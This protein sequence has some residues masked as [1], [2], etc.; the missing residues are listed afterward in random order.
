MKTSTQLTNFP[1]LRRNP[2]LAE[3]TAMLE[4]FPEAALFVDAKSK[5]ILG[6]NSKTSELTLYTHQEL[7]GLDSARLFENFDDDTFWGTTTNESHPEILTLARQNKTGVQVLVTRYDLSPQGKWNL[8]VL[9]PISVL[10]QRLAERQ[11]RSELLESMNTI[12]QALHETELKPGLELLLNAAQ[13]MTGA[14]T[15]GI[16]LQNLA[17][18]NQ[19]FEVVRFSHYGPTG[20]LPEELPA[21]E[22]AQLRT[23]NFWTTS[24]RVPTSLHRTARSAGLTYVASVPLGQP[25]AMIGLVVIAGNQTPPPDQ[26]LEQLQILAEAISALVEHHTRRSNIARDLKDM[27]WQ[28]NIHRAIENVVFDGVIVLDPDLTI[29][30]LNYACESILGYSN[31]E[32]QKHSVEDILIGTETLMPALK[33][34]QQGDQTLKQAN[35]RLYHRSGQAFLAQVSTVPTIVDEKL[36]GIIILIQDLSEQEQIQS[37][38]QELER[39]A[40][41]GEVTAIFAHEVRNPINNISTGLQL[42]AYN[43]P[44]DDPKQEVI[45][46]LNQ[47]C[48][49]LSELMKSVLAFSR[50]AEYEMVAIDLC[51]LINR[52]VDRARPRMSNA[53]VEPHLQFDDSL[54]PIEGNQRA[55]EQVF[56]NLIS[57]AIQA[58]RKTGGTLAIK[59][60]KIQSSGDSHY[61]QVDVADSGPGIPKENIDRIFQPFFTTKSDGTGLGLAITKRIVTAHKGNIQVTSF[62]GG[63]VF[64]VQLPVLEAL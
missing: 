55:L 62:P 21:L 5:R 47:D 7:S 8:I 38:T 54:P 31:Q 20:N 49:R 63:T 60:Q 15:L 3:I 29:S 36:L 34:A 50:P 59:M 6:T 12:S 40:L 35:M 45:G 39:Q 58:M 48:D 26:V 18:N 32:A 25:N 19:D 9:E 17:K 44:E 14:S 23:A 13:T 53:K 1:R 43:L 56:T 52:L 27:T 10:E 16:Y 30:R 11:R 41:L 37:Q 22:L 57:N 46:R 64:H 24:K 42:M 33:A 2:G 51:S 61:I 4:I 28:N